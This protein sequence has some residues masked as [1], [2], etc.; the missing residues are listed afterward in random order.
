MEKGGSPGDHCGVEWSWLRLVVVD[1]GRVPGGPSPKC[2]RG[3]PAQGCLLSARAYLFPTS[4]ATHLFF[5]S[6]F[7]F[8]PKYSLNSHLN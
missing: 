6:I 7:P 5:S 4:F 2:E 8:C 1:G 3:T